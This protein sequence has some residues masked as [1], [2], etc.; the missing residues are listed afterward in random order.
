[1][2]AQWW[3]LLVQAYVNLTGETDFARSA[4]CQRGIRLI[5]NIFLRD[6]FEVFPT[7]LVPDASFMVDRRMS[8][9]GHP[10]EIQSLF[11]GFGA[12]V[13][14]SL[15][16]ILFAG[17]RERVAVAD[18]PLPFRGAAIASLL[19]ALLVWNVKPQE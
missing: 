5:M 12:A 15:V 18:V 2:R 7:L 11:Y 14:F 6:R 9:Y 13:G 1:M 8:V 4:E 10:L 3:V 19:L 16:M 17:V